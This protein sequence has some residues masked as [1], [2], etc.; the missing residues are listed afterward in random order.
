MGI[1]E[2][3][4]AAEF[5]AFFERHHAELARF[6]HL[7]TGEAE[8]ADD[9]AAD[10]LLAVWDRWDRVR[11]ADH[12]VAY[13]R[14]VVA[15]MARSR[16]RSAVRERRRVA[17]YWSR[18]DEDSAGPDVAAVVDVR[19]ALRR[20]PFRKRACVV[21]RHALDL[22]ERDTAMAL[23]ISVG[24]VKSQTSKGVAELQRLLGS[25]EA[26]EMGTAAMLRAVERNG[27][28]QVPGA[29]APAREVGH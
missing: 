19:R 9:L 28:A 3:E 29:V 27:S 1:P 5:H 4:P 10:A 12:P 2:Q 6:A 20:L 26:T 21:L 18:H 17:L 23:G 11:A 8:A 15:N 24:T 7:V 22:S 16:I 25:E 14:G 13:A